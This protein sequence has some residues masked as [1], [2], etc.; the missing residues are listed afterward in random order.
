[1]FLLHRWS[2][3]IDFVLASH[4]PESDASNDANK[5]KDTDYAAY[6]SPFATRPTLALEPL[7]FLNVRQS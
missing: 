5:G 3:T 1:M 6:A 7:A 2:E 4:K